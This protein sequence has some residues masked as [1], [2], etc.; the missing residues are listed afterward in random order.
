MELAAAALS[1]PA[2]MSLLLAITDTLVAYGAHAAGARARGLAAAARRLARA[3]AR[4]A[5]RAAHA[6]APG[7][8]VTSP[9]PVPSRAGG[10]G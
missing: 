9:H 8:W 3:A 7:L 2:A 5:H 1:P 10:V 6:D 4:R